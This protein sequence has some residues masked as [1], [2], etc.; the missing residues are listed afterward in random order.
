VRMP[1]NSGASRVRLCDTDDV[2]AEGT[3][4]LLEAAIAAGSVRRFVQVSSL[5]AIGPSSDGTPVDEET[6]PHPVNNYGRSKLAGEV[7]V[8]GAAEQ[9][10][11]TVIRP[12]LVYGPRDHETLSFFKAI[13]RGTLPILGDGETR[14][15]SSTPPTAPRPSSPLVAQL[16][17]RMR[18]LN[19]RGVSPNAL[20]KRAP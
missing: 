12:P 2:N 11:V 6:P 18:D 9:I 17:R 8:L 14:S 20:S 16:W 5:A 15:A 13:K 10:P 4:N 1:G 7:A 3:E 19:P